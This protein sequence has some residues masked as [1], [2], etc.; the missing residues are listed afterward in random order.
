[1]G[2]LTLHQKTIVR[3]PGQACIPYLAFEKPGTIF[4][5][6]LDTVPTSTDMVAS[7]TYTGGSGT[8]ND[9]KIGMSL[10][11]GSS[12][13]GR[14]LGIARI[15]KDP[16]AG[17]IYIGEESEID[18]TAA[19]PVYLT[20]VD[21]F[22]L[23]SKHIKVIDETTF[24]IDYD[25]TYTDQHSVF[26][27]TPMMGVDA[28]LWRT[29][30]TISITWPSVAGSY[31]IDGSSVASY[32]FSCPG[33]FS[34]S[35]MTTATPTLTFDTDG[36][37][38]LY[39]TVTATNG[40][41]FTAC[42]RIYVFSKD[43]MPETNFV[44]STNP[45]GSYESG[46][47][48]FEI[49]MLANAD[50]SFVKDR[51]KVILF[52][53]DYYAGTEEYIGPYGKKEMD[54]TVCSGWIVG[55]SIS[56]NPMTGTTSFRVTGAQE[57]MKRIGGFPVGLER[58]TSGADGWTNMQTL[59]VRKFLWH[60]LHWRTTA[61]AIMDCTLTTDT[62]QMVSIDNLQPNFWA[63]LL[64]TANAT[65]LADPYV[66]RFGNFHCQVN[67]QLVPD[68]NRGSF[69][70]IM[71]LEKQ[72][73]E[74]TLEISRRVVSEYGRV[75]LSGVKIVDAEK[76]KSI[77]SL[78]PGHVP[79]RYGDVVPADN[80]LLSSQEQANSLAGL[81]LGH[82]NRAYDFELEIAQ[83]NRMI[84]IVPRSYLGLTVDAADNLR[85]I[86]Y[87]G[88]IVV[89]DIEYIFD[90]ES[91][92]MIV[93][94]SAEQESVEDI[95]INGDIPP[96]GVVPPDIPP[97][98]PIPPLPPPPPG[99]LPGGANV[100]TVVIFA[101]DYGFFYTEDFDTGSPHWYAMNG[102]LDA[103]HLDNFASFDVTY[104]GRL[105]AHFCSPNAFPFE[106]INNPLWT[107]Q[108]NIDVCQEIWYAEKVG[109]AWVRIFHN[110]MLTPK[111]DT[112]FPRGPAIKAM[113]INR[114]VADSIYVLG[115]GIYSI[116]SQT[117]CQFWAGGSGGLSKVGDMTGTNVVSGAYNKGTMIQFS[118][119]AFGYAGMNGAT[120]NCLFAIPSSGT[121]ISEIVN[122][123]LNSPKIVSS[124]VPGLAGLWNVA[125]PYATLD[126]ASFFNLVNAPIP[127]GSD[128]AEDLYDS[129]GNTAD[130]KYVL[131]S[132][133]GGILL[134]RSS[135]F[136]TT[137]GNAPSVSGTI[138]AVWNLIDPLIWV[139][140]F[141]HQMI[142]SED[143][144]D[145]YE[146][147]TGDLWSWTSTL[148]N[149][150]SIRNA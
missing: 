83:L 77:F 56:I 32:L 15:R 26:D 53:R 62:R 61:T 69:F 36:Q 67:Q 34:T 87:N 100:K 133:I 57:W 21:T 110:A 107:Q 48:N 25:I 1:M 127:Y 74:G 104:D 46:G 27:P 121:T 132:D 79:K 123:I 97:I 96:D 3:N 65:I 139:A 90:Q 30:A 92:K 78:A 91:G 18:W 137:F 102:G 113:A 16:I 59:T 108:P 9:V 20:V 141:A 50:T 93:R 42:R 73:W 23:W 124:R 8:I 128:E 146:N 4:T 130:G 47:W 149:I 103:A 81:I 43:D 88:N 45:N 115:V 148:V 109:D 12:S 35:G 116:L 40:K 24:K 37:Y 66:D 80:L 140:G 126:G 147:K 138:T 84:E 33:A 150:R 99:I 95:S 38:V 11:V 105:F 86:S 98:P 54:N 114:G 106:V 76:I 7:I 131:M 118:S 119:G 19:T 85:G 68:A 112:P 143:F 111:I 28:I 142:Y 39:L 82:S 44:I 129:I 5:A 122:H 89:R 2:A 94:V 101:E 135:D 31:V 51:T 136:G 29:G 13:G 17:T 63:Q 134:K 71:D 22:G 117:L 72:D 14:E 52:S 49:T 64:E 60:M 75:E 6:L 41:T 144:F 10:F 120:E 55:E 145:T 70:T 125:T 58:K